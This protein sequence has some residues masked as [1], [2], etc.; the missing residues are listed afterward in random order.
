MAHPI[1]TLLTSLLDQISLSWGGDPGTGRP[2]HQEIVC[3]LIE[4]GANLNLADKDG[5]TALQHAQ[6]KGHHEIVVML[7]EAGAR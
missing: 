2:R 1:P 4:A 3:L 5:V 6:R 7:R